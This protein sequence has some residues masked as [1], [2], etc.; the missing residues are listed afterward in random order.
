MKD[1]STPF[2]EEHVGFEIDHVLPP[3]TVYSP[4][5]SIIHNDTVERTYLSTI[6]GFNGTANPYFVIKASSTLIP[7]QDF[8]G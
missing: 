5:F 7:P 1:E 6:S 2:E 4:K 3:S 8:I